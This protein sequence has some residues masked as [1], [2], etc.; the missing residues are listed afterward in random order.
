MDGAGDGDPDGVCRQNSQHLRSSLL[1]L[2]RDP[3]VCAL[4]PGNP[5]QG[6]DEDLLLTP[7]PVQVCDGA[8]D[9]GDMSDELPGCSRKIFHSASHC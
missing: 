4:L 7:P 2:C 6:H 3:A 5:D 1:L 9:C 8:D